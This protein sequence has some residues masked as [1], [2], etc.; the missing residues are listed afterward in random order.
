MLIVNPNKTT[1]K[2]GSLPTLNLPVKSFSLQC[3]S[4]CLFIPKA[5]GPASF[6]SLKRS[7][8]PSIS[9]EAV[10]SKLYKSF[11]E[12][13]KRISFQKLDLDINATETFL[14]LS[15]MDDVHTVPKYEI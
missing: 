12:L 11:K 6:K 5:R 8:F 13:V 2:P 9:D 14:K 3:P 7:A 10:N 4:S 1:L 15:K